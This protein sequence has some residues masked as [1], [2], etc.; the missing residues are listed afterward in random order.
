[1]APEYPYALSA[2]DEASI[3]YREKDLASEVMG[4]L[5]FTETLYYTWTGEMPDAGERRVLTA[6]LNSL[7]L[8]GVTPSTLVSRTVLVSEPD[9][10]QAAVASAI[11]GVG[12]RLIGPMK[13]CSEDLQRVS[14]A[15]DRKTAIEQL[16]EEYATGDDHFPGIG[17]PHLDPVDPRAVRLF[18]LADEADVAGEHVE[19]L[20]EIRDAINPDLPI[21]ATGAIAALTADMGLPPAGARGIAIVSRT[22]GVLAEVLAEQDTPFAS[23]VWQHVDEHATP[24]GAQD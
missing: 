10:V 20:E 5:G 14:A 18:E 12:S 15:D 19:I 4:E 3:S 7:M 8:H 6:M 16:V 2:H 13:E 24:G 17:H 11:N 22:A 23:E 9:A 21:N 1:M